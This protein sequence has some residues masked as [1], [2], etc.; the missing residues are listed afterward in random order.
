[1]ALGLP[2]VFSKAV[3]VVCENLSYNSNYEIKTEE[4]RLRLNLLP[5]AKISANHIEITDKKTKDNIVLETPAIRTRLLPLLSG[6]VHIN[7][8]EASN[9]GIDSYL[10]NKPELDKDFFSK[11]SNAKVKCDSV[12][13]DKFK[14]SIT[15]KGVK[16]PIL[17]SGKDVFYKK[18]NRYIK[19]HT[20]SS[21]NIQGAVSE[22]KIDLFLPG[23]NDINK[24]VIDVK[25]SN[26]NL[27][28]LGN[29]L[30]HYLPQDLKDVQGIINVDVDKNN[31][32]AVFENCAI[33]MKHS[34][35]SIIFPDVLN[36][37][38]TFALTS[39][40]INFDSIDVD[41]KNI[42]AQLTAMF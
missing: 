12:K 40:K 39:K 42:H 23:N 5:T 29:Y 24:S 14:L 3:P 35:K 11:L 10:D 19:L 13:I 8:I 17:Y 21:V 36:V 26:F 22:A 2:L 37:N 28:P 38:S 20:D 33:L 9:I 15:Q 31:L 6:R 16:T 32:H 41:S 25:I 34:G 4:P 18:N 1:M 7:K 27:E 30:K